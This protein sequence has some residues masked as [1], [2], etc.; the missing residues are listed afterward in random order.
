MSDDTD[1][2]RIENRDSWLR[3][4]VVA[5]VIGVVLWKIATADLDLSQFAFSDL[6]ALLLALFAIG[7]SVA[8]YFKAAETSNALYDNSDRFTKQISEILGRIEAGFGERLRPLDEGY[9]G[10]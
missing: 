3:F 5:A 6:L 1:P 7:L 9:S 4:L 10:L 2:G 8:F